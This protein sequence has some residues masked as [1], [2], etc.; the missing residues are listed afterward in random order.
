MAKKEKLMVIPLG[1]LGEIGKNMTVIQYGNDI[2]VIDAGLAFP[3]DDMFGIDLVIPDMSYLIENRDK[4]RAV[5]I[6]H[7][8]ED[9]IGGL[10][11]LLNEVNVP[12]YATKLVCGLIEGKLK[13][14]HITNYTLNE[15]HHGDEVQIGC[16]KVGFIHTNHSIPDA[17]A[18]YFRTPVGTIVHTGDFKMDLTPVD[19]RQMDIHKFAELGRRG[20]L[21]LMS[22]STNAERAGYT[23]SETTVGHAFR[24]AFRA[25]KGRIILATFASNISRIQQAINTAV[26]FKRKVTVLGRSMVNNVQIAIE[27]GYLDVPEGVLIEPDELNRYP[28]DQILILTTG[29]QG[30]PMAGLSRM[31]SN[32]H[33]SVSIMPGDT[34]IISAT[35]IPGNETGVGRTIDNLMRLG[36]NVIAGRDKKI[37]VSGHA[38]QEELKLMLELIKPKYFIPVHGEYRM[39]KTHGDLAVMMGVAKDHVLIGDNGQIFEFSNRSGHKTGHV[40]AGRVFVDGLGVGDVGNIVIRDRQQLAMEGVVIVVMTLAKGTSH[41]LAGPDIVSRGFVYV[42]DSE[43]LIR[44]AHDRVAAVLERCEAGNIREWAVIKSQVRDTLSR[45]LYEK[46]RRRP[47]ILPIIMEV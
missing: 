33:R 26:Q 28:D 31:A 34:V 44:E 35:P 22:D 47:M 45:Y 15:V 8:H 21:L 43:E 40:N 12:V 1:G 42:R 9:H 24:K 25:A 4:V 6:T 16:M 3:D 5:V 13:E 32:N 10:S 41:P 37:H 7:G 2:I 23:E 30:E 11:Y 17:S 29:S 38:S 19:G 39:L 46:T 27:L 20:V 18:L 36:A 14:N